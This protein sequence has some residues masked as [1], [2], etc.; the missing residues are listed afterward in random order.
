MFLPER[1]DQINV[2]VFESE[3]DE[4]AAAIVR[5]GILHLVQLDDQEPWAENL[6]NFE[7]A[8]VRVRIE[9][10]RSR[11]AVV[12]RDLGI[13]DESLRPAETPPDISMGDLAEIDRFVS[14]LEVAMQAPVAR[15]SEIRRKLDR[16]EAI[17]NEVSPL[18]DLGLPIQKTPYSFLDIHYGE[19]LAENFEII[20]EKIAPLAA[21]AFP[22][23]KRGKKE[24]VVLIGLK[25]DRLKLKRILSEASFEEVEIAAETK[26]ELPEVTGE[27]GKQ[28]DALKDDLAAVGAELASFRER[29]VSKITEYYR[30]LRVA[31][32]LLKFKNFLKRTKKTFIFSGWIPV[33]ERKAVEREIMAAA[34]GRA[35]I[36][37]H[38]PEEIAG[39]RAG[40]IKVPVLLKHP[41]FFKPFEMLISS[42]GLP[43]YK[44]I[45]PT[46]F[47]AIT[48]LFMFGIMFGDVGH[49]S[50]LV[51]IGWL[52]YGKARNKGSTMA[53]FGRL[54]MYCGV[55]SIVFGF[56]FGSVFGLEK[57]IPHIWMKPMNNVMYFFKVAIYYGIG[58]IMLGIAFNLINSIRTRNFQALVFEHAGLLVTIMYWAGIVSVSMFLSNKPI[59]MKLL[60][61]AVGGPILVIFLRE[62][63]VAIASHRKTRFESGLGMYLFESLIEVVE[64]FTGYLANTVSFIRVAAFSLAHVGLFIAVFSLA[65]MVR[66]ASGGVVYAGIIHVLGNVGIIA[67]E[68]LIVSI[69]AIRLEYYEFFGKFFVSGGVAYKPLGLG[70]QLSREE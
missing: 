50:V 4:V 61:F 35:I 29:N 47:M 2:L 27:L 32:L 68:G 45:D 37:V 26:K 20:K 28:I 54:G 53:L 63:I 17:A 7:A 66:D 21:V 46:L 11:I 18:L 23:T 34:K 60:L 15:R 5:L 6:R 52:L 67:L 1:M 14:S 36:E 38:A 70:A 48:F 30:S 69:Q 31:A 19:V 57:A 24:L 59:P 58:V 40:R 41:A 56:L 22:A 49:G 51:A 65:G 8:D 62:P 44:V 25:S 42:Y 9:I 64:I 12:M 55:S 33:S 13:E 39:V 3:L 43:D 16:L 10:L